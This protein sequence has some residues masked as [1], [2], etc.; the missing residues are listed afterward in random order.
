MNIPVEALKAIQLQPSRAAVL[1]VLSDGA[2]LGAKYMLDRFDGAAL[3]CGEC[4]W[5][6]QVAQEAGAE[7]YVRC[8]Q[9]TREVNYMQQCKKDLEELFENAIR[10]A[11]GETNGHTGVHPATV[12]PTE[13]PA[14]S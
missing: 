4:Q 9:H 1:Q 7:K 6:R 12:P 3:G 11:N 2:R 5:N 10:G 14:A 13:P 8:L